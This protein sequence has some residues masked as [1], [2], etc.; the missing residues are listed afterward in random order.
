[1][2]EGRRER[3]VREGRDG[4]RKEGGREQGRE[5]EME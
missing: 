5:K 3:G 4:R 2:E 1:M